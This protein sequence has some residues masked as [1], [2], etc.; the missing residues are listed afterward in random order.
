[1]VCLTGDIH[2]SSLKIKEQAYIPDRGDSEV[3]IAL[4]Y[5]RLVE[6]M[7]IKVTFYTTG[8]TLKEE[9][10]TF[11][12]IAR[13]P[14]VE[15]GGHTFGGL[16]RPLGSRLKELLTGIPGVSHATAHGSY[17]R[18]RRDVERMIAIVRDRTSRPLLSWRSHG[19]VRDANT[20]R[21]LRELGIRY[22]SDDLAWDKRRPERTPEGLISHPINVIMDHDHIYHAHRTPEYVERQKKDWGFPDDPT[23]ESY[24]IEEWGRIVERQV[25]AIDAEGGLATVLMHPLC[26]YIVD[27]FE[28]ARRLLRLF[29]HFRTIWASEVGLFLPEY[30]TGGNPTRRD[31]GE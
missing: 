21:I 11:A 18:Q 25:L 29:S 13:S 8:K 1:M 5:L 10:Q 27:R 2:H 6:E 17:R 26:M 7:G 15:I 9:W 23:T 16:P 30:P 4:R 20:Y 24:P 12:P 28:T 19:L 14:L 22:I 3:A 31:N